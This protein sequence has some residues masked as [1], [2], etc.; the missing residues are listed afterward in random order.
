[1]PSISGGVFTYSVTFG[2]N[3][4]GVSVVSGTSYS[5]AFGG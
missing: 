5:V 2:G 3:T 4:Y 1:M